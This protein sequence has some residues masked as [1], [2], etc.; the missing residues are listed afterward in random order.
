MNVKEK[1]TASSKTPP[2]SPRMQQRYADR[3]Q[4]RVLEAYAHQEAREGARA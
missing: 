2:L 1:L 3:T 4:M